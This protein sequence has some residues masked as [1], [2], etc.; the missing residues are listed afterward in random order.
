M[1][2]SGLSPSKSPLFPTGVAT[3]QLPVASLGFSPNSSFHRTTGL[4]R[5]P[6]FTEVKSTPDTEVSYWRYSLPMFFLA[7]GIVD[8]RNDARLSPRTEPKL[9]T[10]LPKCRWFRRT[11]LAS[12]GHHQTEQCFHRVLSLLAESEPSR[13]T[14]RCQ[15]KLNDV[16][17]RRVRRL[18]VRQRPHLH[19]ADRKS[20]V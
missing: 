6:L 9:P 18:L 20:V 4:L 5:L 16:P 12:E 14:R 11:T 2:A 10:W 19:V 7:E 17:P 13:L 3:C 1:A 8:C 15:P